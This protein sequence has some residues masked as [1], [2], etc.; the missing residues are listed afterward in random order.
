MYVQSES[1]QT[2]I[3]KKILSANQSFITYS[4]YFSENLAQSW[5]CK[6]AS[7]KFL[8]S[9]LLIWDKSLQ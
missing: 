3:L 5:N 8:G 1:S 9:E 7:V 2:Q 4:F 6:T